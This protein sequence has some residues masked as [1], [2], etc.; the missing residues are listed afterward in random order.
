[1]ALSFIRHWQHLASTI[2]ILTGTASLI[3]HL[4]HEFGLHLSLIWILHVEQDWNTSWIWR[5]LVPPHASMPHRP[6]LHLSWTWIR[7]VELAKA[8]NV[9]LQSPKFR[10]KLKHCLGIEMTSCCS[11]LNWLADVFSKPRVVAGFLLHKYLEK[12]ISEWSQA[13][14]YIVPSASEKMVFEKSLL[15][16]VCQMV[17]LSSWFFSEDVFFV[18]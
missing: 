3:A 4:L 14:R 10:T 1:M 9:V 17:F 18:F 8:P 6:W 13:P 16:S 7:L 11:Q 12:R 5:C 2:W 15:E